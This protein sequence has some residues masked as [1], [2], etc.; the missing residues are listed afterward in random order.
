MQI[1]QTK[2]IKKSYSIESYKENTKHIK[3]LPIA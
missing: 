1:E 2:I 3:M